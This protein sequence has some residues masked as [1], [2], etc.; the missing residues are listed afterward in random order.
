[1]STANLE[2]KQEVDQIMTTYSV[3]VADIQQRRDQVI[4]AF[5]EKVRQ[6]RVQEIKNS[7]SKHDVS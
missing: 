1:M 7:L 4:Q 2:K 5:L 6:R 3:K